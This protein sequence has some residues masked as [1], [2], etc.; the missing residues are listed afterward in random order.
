MTGPDTPRV[1]IRRLVEVPES[2]R[3]LQPR[4]MTSAAE[5]ATRNAALRDLMVPAIA[6]LAAWA[7]AGAR[8]RASDALE[9]FETIYDDRPLKDNRGGSGFNDSLWLFVLARALS[10]ALIIESGTHRGHSAWLFRQACP[11]AEIHSFDIAWDRL[12]HREE[13]NTYHNHDW[14]KADQNLW[15]VT[16]SLVFFDDHISHAR[17]IEEAWARGFRLLLFDDNFPAHQLHAT[18]GPPVP[19]LAMLLDPSLV[20][21]QEIAWTRNGKAYSFRFQEAEAGPARS[22]VADHLVLPELA[23]VTA[24][25]PGSGLTLAKLVD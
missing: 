21:G 24:Y 7:P 11:E 9:A 20:D 13:S 18:G 14:S 4:R 22:L 23:P 17:R 8:E 19:S 10:P 25:P 5:I 3:A 16:D 1:T 2:Q 15:K 12:A 6:R